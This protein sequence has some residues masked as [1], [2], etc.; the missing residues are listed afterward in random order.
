MWYESYI[1][2]LESRSI[3]IVKSLWEQP[4]EMHDIIAM[5][6]PTEYD[7]KSLSN[8]WIDTSNLSGKIINQFEL[9]FYY[10]DGSKKEVIKAAK[11]I[12]SE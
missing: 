7:I 6:P 3:Y 11:V 8:N 12:I 1:K 5:Q 2:S 4:N 9:W 10:D